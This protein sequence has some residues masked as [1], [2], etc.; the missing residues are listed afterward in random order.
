MG[1]TLYFSTQD[2]LSGWR[3]NEKG[4][5]GCL[6]GV[7]EKK[8]GLRNFKQP[9]SWM[10]AFSLPEDLINLSDEPKKSLLYR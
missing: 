7:P 5:A 1:I 9:E 8:S 10:E 3:E 4:T 6:C 2:F